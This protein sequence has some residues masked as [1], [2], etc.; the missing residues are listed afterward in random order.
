MQNKELPIPSTIGLDQKAIEI[1]RI[2]AANGAQHVSLA[3]GL[4]R[5]PA[6]WGI[7]LVDLAKHVANAYATDSAANKNDV[8][9]RIKEGF[10]TEWEV[11]TDDPK[12][13]LT[14]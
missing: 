3:V 13:K 2:W 11:A 4:W 5:D 6:A 1:A 9:R 10:D 12:G 14:S 8:L 7:M